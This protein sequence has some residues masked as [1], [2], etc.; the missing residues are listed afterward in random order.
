MGFFGARFAGS[1]QKY[2]Y[3]IRYNTRWKGLYKLDNCSLGLYI[4]RPN[5]NLIGP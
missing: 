3:N 5:I 1:L 2:T 4:V